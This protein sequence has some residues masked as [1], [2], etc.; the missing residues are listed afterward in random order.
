M[1]SLQSKQDTRHQE[2]DLT[3]ALRANPPPPK[4]AMLWLRWLLHRI[5]WLL[6]RSRPR[7]ALAEGAWSEQPKGKWTCQLC[8]LGLAD[9]ATLHRFND[10]T[11]CKSCHTEAEDACV[12]SG[13]EEPLYNEK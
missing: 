1:S 13:D 11:L 3:G 10:M 12:S 8:K 2:E 9:D 4:A 6:R 7:R 5:L